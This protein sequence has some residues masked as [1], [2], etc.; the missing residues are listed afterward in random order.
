V[1][2]YVISEK[3]WHYWI[4]NFGERRI[5]PSWGDTDICE[6]TRCFLQGLMVFLAAATAITAIAT[7]VIAS[8]INGIAWMFF[9][10]MIEPWTQVFILTIVSLGFLCC[11]YYMS[12][13]LKHRK[14]V[15]RD[16]LHEL[17]EKGEY[18]PPPP[19]FLTLAYRKFKDKTCVRLTFKEQK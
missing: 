2:P 4:V 10:Y 13:F 1:K 3:S 15:K 5:R 14:Q 6:Y 7:F 8:I 11:M 9:G 18:T 16:R 17:M 19:S 12:L